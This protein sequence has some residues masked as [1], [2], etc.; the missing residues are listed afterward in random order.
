MRLLR[1]A[2]LAGAVAAGLMVVAAISML[3]RNA[4]LGE[5]PSGSAFASDSPPSSES[6]MESASATALPTPSAQPT[7]TGEIPGPDATPPAITALLTGVSINELVQPLLSIGIPCEST[8][9]GYPG[10]EGGYTLYCSGEA[11]GYAVSL[12][13]PWWTGT[14]IEEYH[15]SIL[16]LDA[17]P[18]QEFL[19]DM[20]VIFA[21]VALNG[22]QASE[23]ASWV[24]D[25]MSNPQCLELPCERTFNTVTIVLQL[26]SAGSVD[27]V[28]KAPPG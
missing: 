27:I 17:D 2:G 10:Q 6:P 16:P 20:V 8:Q 24:T 15:L 25:N 9:G 22:E 21:Q 28:G 1:I 18:D 19:A 4:P 11:S 23:A 5:D 3:E 26:G 14:A 13:L 12:Q 7:I